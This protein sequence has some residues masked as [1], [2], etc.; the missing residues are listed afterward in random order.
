MYTK[1]TVDTP[2]E[3]CALPEVMS[4]YCV[5][6]VSGSDSRVR[7]A[8]VNRDVIVYSFIRHWLHR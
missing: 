7:R 1:V 4:A 2:F 8:V 6:S 5:I 3:T